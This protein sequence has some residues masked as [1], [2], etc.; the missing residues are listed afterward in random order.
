MERLGIDEIIHA[1]RAVPFNCEKI[2]GITGVA[3]DSRKLN[4]GDLFAA[5]K[6]ERFDGH[7]FAEAAVASGAAVVL[8]Q[9]K[10]DADIPYIL[11]E[12]T[13]KAL[14]SLAKYYKSK[15]DI[16]FI[17]VTGSSGKTTTKDMTASVLA[18]KYKVLKTE[19][20]FNNAIGLPLTLF[21]LE[22]KHEI[23]VVEM[24]MNSLGEIETL[25]DIVRPET[26]IISNVGTAHIEKLKSRDNIL[27]AKME[28]FTYFDRN[29]TAILN[30]DNDM[31]S[32]VADK[33]Y[34]ILRFGLNE[35]ND[36]RA[37]NIV[38]KGEEGIEFDVLYQGQKEAY[39]V[40]IPGIHNVY[41]ALSAICIGKLYNISSSQI[42][43]GLLNFKPSK[44]RMEI[45][46]GRHDTKII[47]D[48]YNAN[49][50]SMMA[51]ISALA[52][53]ETQGRR[54]CIFGDMFELG[55]YSKEGHE[56]VGAFAAE[57]EIDV[58]AAVGKMADYVIKG[59]ARIKKEDMKLISYSSNQEVIDNME[60][61]VQS[62][63]IILIK[64]SRGMNM[65]NIVESL[66]EGR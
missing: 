22:H 8:S 57:K 13:I 40:P 61:I 56:S 62:Q 31:L 16:P 60:N 35:G 34:K 10:L 64:G 20:N 51:A 15:F 9:E 32:K 63:D 14:H 23:C 25:A 18:E 58:I 48:V 24:G 29:G 47:N 1:C 7:Q 30:G 46:T 49:P 53:M 28:I 17:A 19:G 66:R 2:S 5:I 33:Q 6:G 39:H 44:M 37:V 42:Q 54:V 50:D 26:G 52:S 65:E 4:K 36:C 55:E 43:S 12:D 38:E 21:N 3:T 41:N 11:V 45:F 59:A 27:K